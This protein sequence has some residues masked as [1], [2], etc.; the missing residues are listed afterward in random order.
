MIGPI[1]KRE[2]GW[3]LVLLG[4]CLVCV[5]SAVAADEPDFSGVWRNYRD[6]ASGGG[7]RAAWAEDAPMTAEGRAK[8]AEYEALIEATGSTPGGF[9]VGTGMPG[10]MLGS[11]GYP[12]EIIQRPEQVTIVYEAH[13]ELRRVYIGGDEIDPAD[14]IPT[15]NG[16][17]TGRWED[18]TLV[19]ETI[20][21][22]EAVDQQSAHSDEARI[23]ERY[24]F[25]GE[26]DD[27]R[28]L[29]EAQLT[30]TD[31]R[32]YTAPV[33]ATKTWVEAN[34]DVRMLLY[35]CT[36]PDWEDYLDERRRELAQASE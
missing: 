18:E 6:P 25:S 22:K 4:A 20:S 33:T 19:V 30:V 16:F 23:V 34:D 32:F 1:L 27:G 26:D 2:G 15:R 8:V 24:S 13:N 3:V 36:E 9:C 5:S 31:P 11:G 21:L 28:R 35:E 17:S 12:M 10:S 7:R 29:L 14:L